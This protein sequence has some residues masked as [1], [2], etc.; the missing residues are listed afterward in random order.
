MEA[1]PTNEPT[2]ERRSRV[3]RLRDDFFPPF[4][5]RVGDFRV[6]YDV[7]DERREVG[8]FRASAATPPGPCGSGRRYQKCCLTECAGRTERLRA[9][10]EAFATCDLCARTLGGRA[11]RVAL[12]DGTC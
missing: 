2:V 1:I 5:L 9:E 10:N 3:K 11:D 12:A 4:R 8:R 6:Y 7:D